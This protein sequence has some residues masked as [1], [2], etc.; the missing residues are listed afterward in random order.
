M[1]PSGYLARYPD[2][3]SKQAMTPLHQQPKKCLETQCDNDRFQRST[4]C[5]VHKMCAAKGCR[6]QTGNQQFCSNHKRSHWHNPSRNNRGTGEPGSKRHCSRTVIAGTEK[7]YEEDHH[8]LLDVGYFKWKDALKD[9]PLVSI[10]DFN[11]VNAFGDRMN[12]MDLLGIIHSSSEESA[13]NSRKSKFVN[14]QIN[15]R[16]FDEPPMIRL[17][18]TDD[19][20]LSAERVSVLNIIQVVQYILGFGV[21]SKAVLIYCPPGTQCQDWHMDGMECENAVI[22]PLS[23]GHTHTEFLSYDYHSM[24]DNVEMW[25]I[26]T[27]NKWTLDAK[28]IQGFVSFGELNIFDLI[29]FNTSRIHRGPSNLKDSARTVLFLS[30]P[31]SAEC[32]EKLKRD[33]SSVVFN[34]LFISNKKHS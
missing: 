18:G 15:D 13:D 8:Y 11:R 9:N 1:R 30:W 29:L 6:V 14:L 7:D 16:M 26:K 17:D 25:W 32:V 21:P 33:S 5:L 28:D 12:Q 24:S 19:Q 31:A 34:E 27:P 2:I 20:I 10:E 3:E 4:R 23:N 22:I